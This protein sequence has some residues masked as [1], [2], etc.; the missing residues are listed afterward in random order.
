MSGFPPPA[1]QLSSV[2]FCRHG[3]GITAIDVERGA[4]G[5]TR[6][7]G[8][9]ESAGSS[10]RQRCPL[11]LRKERKFNIL[12]K[13]ALAEKLAPAL[14]TLPETLSAAAKRD[15]SYPLFIIADQIEGWRTTSA[16][17]G[18]VELRK[19]DTLIHADRL[20]YHPLETRSR[21]PAMCACCRMV[22]RSP[23]RT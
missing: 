17:R 8:A 4:E 18:N 13:R 3:W 20:T 14:L 12:K 7:S 16:Q 9:G 15:D 1:L 5:G 2:A 6:P 11:R 22:P 23:G 10:G 21:Q 19:V